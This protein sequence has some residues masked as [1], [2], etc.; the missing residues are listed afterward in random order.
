MTQEDRAD[1]F[2]C[3]LEQFVLDLEAMVQRL[4]DSQAPQEPPVPVA[5]VVQLVPKRPDAVP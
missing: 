1:L 4:R 2:I 5:A 3:R